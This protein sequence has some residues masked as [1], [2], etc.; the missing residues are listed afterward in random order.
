MGGKEERDVT[1]GAV[2]RDLFV[3][4]FP[5]CLSLSLFPHVP[6]TLQCTLKE[7]TGPS[8]WHVGF[9]HGFHVGVQ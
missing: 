8:T 2:G 7:S 3:C 6:S 5:F 1:M 9:L 4:L